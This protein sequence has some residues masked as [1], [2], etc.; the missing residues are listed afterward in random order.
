M[1]ALSHA[2]EAKGGVGG[3]ENGKVL[4]GS[5]KT[6]IGHAEAAAG[7]V[8]MTKVVISALAWCDSSSLEL[9]EGESFD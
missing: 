6:N 3:S 9:L 1:N 8:V 2:I 5:G 4:I 7:M